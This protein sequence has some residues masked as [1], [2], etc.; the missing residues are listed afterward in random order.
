MM[1]S[2]VADMQDDV[3]LLRLASGRQKPEGLMAS[4]VKSDIFKRSIGEKKCVLILSAHSD[5]MTQALIQIEYNVHEM[6]KIDANV[7]NLMLRDRVRSVER[8]IAVFEV[9]IQSLAKGLSFFR[10][11]DVALFFSRI[12]ISSIIKK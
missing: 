2:D 9:T 3:M 10:F 7:E 8:E 6:N 11:E 5:V 12:L 1:D 4:I